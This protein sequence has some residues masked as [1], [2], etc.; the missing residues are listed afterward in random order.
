MGMLLSANLGQEATLLDTA[1][2]LE[3]AQPWKQITG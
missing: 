1:Y 3:A 2:Q